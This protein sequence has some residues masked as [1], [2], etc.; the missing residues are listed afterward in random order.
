[1]LCSRFAGERAFNTFFSS[2]QAFATPSLS[3]PGSSV[4]DHKV[5]HD[6]CE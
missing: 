5:F 1:M 2:N 4:G 3:Q 6:M